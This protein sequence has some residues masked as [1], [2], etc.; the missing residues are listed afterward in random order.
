[1][2]WSPRK[3]S[4]EDAA[5]MEKEGKERRMM[6][7]R[8]DRSQMLEGRSREAQ[9]VTGAL[10]ALRGGEEAT[11]TGK[12]LKAMTAAT[13]RN[14]GKAKQLKQQLGTP[15]R[16][17]RAGPPDTTGIHCA[18]TPTKQERVTE[19]AEPRAMSLNTTGAGA[20]GPYSSIAPA[21][22]GSTLAPR[23][24]PRPPAREG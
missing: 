3:R 18:G 21:A 22:A 4:L 1:M 9:E 12:V 13:S 7:A 23:P 2:E 11:V 6:L 14:V 16:S 10:P 20:Q 15:T 19:R 17:A 24:P 8:P 5:A